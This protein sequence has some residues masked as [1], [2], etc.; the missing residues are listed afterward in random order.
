[1]LGAPRWAVSRGRGRSGFRVAGR[2][3][4]VP[5]LTEKLKSQLA[6]RYEWKRCVFGANEREPAHPTSLTMPSR[7]STFYGSMIHRQVEH[8]TRALLTHRVSLRDF[9]SLAK[10]VREK[11][12]RCK[13]WFR[14]RVGHAR[15]YDSLRRMA[16]D[17]LKPMTLAL[18]RY[19]VRRRWE[20]VGVEVPC[21]H[22]GLGI[23]TAA[24]WV[25]WTRA[26]FMVIELKTGYARNYFKHTNHYLRGLWTRVRDSTYALHQL[27]LRYTE[28]LMKATYPGRQWAPGRVLRINARYGI[29][30]FPRPRW[31]HQPRL[32]PLR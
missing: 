9:M 15:G 32:V 21:T 14:E 2:G 27:Q 30:S 25:V 1:M 8:L 4:F 28:E 10:R 31:L 20:P 6:P 22:P 24:D 18:M 23:A 7:S 29:T 19:A 16:R 5:G 26:G 17:T 12:P 3:A 11:T 13:A